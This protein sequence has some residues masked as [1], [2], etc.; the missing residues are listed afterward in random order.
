[1]KKWYPFFLI[2]LGFCSFAAY[3][4]AGDT[5]VIK[6]HDNVVIKTDPSIGHTEYSCWSKFPAAAS[7]PYRRVM[8]YLT[9]ECAPGLACGEWDY[10]NYIYLRRVG[11]MA[12]P[13]VNYVMGKFI[14]PYG[15]YW[16][17]ADSWKHGWWLDVTEW[18]ALLRDSVEIVYRHTGYESNTDRG[19]KINLSYHIVEGSPVQDFKAMTPLWNKSYRYG[20]PALPFND[21]VDEKTIT[22]TP[23]TKMAMLWVLQTGHGMDKPDG[24]GEFC[25]KTRALKLDGSTINSRRLW[26]ECGDNSLYP[27]AGTWIMDRAN[28]CP[29]ATVR[30][31]K[32]ELG[33]FTSGS[34]HTLDLEM[35]AYT[36]TKDFGDYDIYSYLFEYGRINAEV[37]VTLDAILAPSKEYET[38]RFN[39]IC[40][41]PVIVI[42]NSGAKPLTSVKVKYGLRGGTVYTYNWTGSLG[43]MEQDTI[44]LSGQSWKLSGVAAF[45]V[46][47]LEPNS[48]ADEFAQDNKGAT[49]MDTV[50]RLPAGFVIEFRSTKAYNETSYRIVNA[51]TGTVAFEKPY[52]FFSAK[53]IYR[54]TVSL[55]T[56]T[57]Y[58]LELM[59]YGDPIPGGIDANSD[60]INFWYWDNMASSYPAYISM[61]DN[62]DGAFKFLNYGTTTVLKDFTNT[63]RTSR[64]IISRGDFGS[65]IFYSFVTTAKNPVGF[66]EVHPDI[67][68]SVYPNPSQ[69]GRFYVSYDLGVSKGAEVQVA[70][71]VGRVLQT[72]PVTDVKGKLELNL[73]GA[74]KGIY[75]MKF[76]KGNECIT[77]KLIC[78]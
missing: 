44:T 22:L 11:G 73:E 19:W 60:G 28:W 23:D 16:S 48:L 67:R 10:N 59:D 33:S 37:D 1:M 50:P 69:N 31:D 20:D 12:T 14:T 68:L 5:V 51:A 76:R 72:I 49:V 7:F 58:R 26:R 56:G 46:E 61:I 30:P 39:P 38:G 4:G 66:D 71:I 24:C 63:Y 54:D 45:E 77:Q 6:G 62:E 3:A 47:L 52:S 2:L 13:P 34:T 18:G 17:A 25:A 65:Y 57:C 64:N 35:E 53:G 41:A 70:D 32:V 9:F 78:Q 8:A 21:S 42:R 36:A 15:F 40:G 43:F 55:D 29:G 75:L 74:A 27:Q